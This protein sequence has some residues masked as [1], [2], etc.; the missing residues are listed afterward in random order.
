MYN[1]TV[2]D[3]L[4]SLDENE[5]GVQKYGDGAQSDPTYHRPIEIDNTYPDSQH[6]PTEP[7]EVPTNEEIRGGG[8]TYEPEVQSVT[9]PPAP[10][11]TLEVPLVTSPS[12]DPINPPSKPS[13]P[14]PKHSLKTTL[15]KDVVLWLDSADGATIAASPSTVAWS[16]G[17]INKEK[18][19]LDKDRRTGWAEGWSEATA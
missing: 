2:S 16:D 14:H 7:P 11:K 9:P 18:V 13:H 1:T 4:Q 8:E 6:R 17:N 10:G 5:G 15:L 3:A 19:R 12:A